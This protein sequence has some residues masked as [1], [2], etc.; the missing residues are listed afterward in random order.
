VFQ[1]V[2]RWEL[3]AVC[4]GVLAVS[5]GVLLLAGRPATYSIE[6]RQRVSVARDLFDGLSRG[7]QA[8][9]GSLEYAP[10]PTILIAMLSVVPSIGP[11]PILARVLAV[12]AACALSCYVY[13]L[14]RRS[15]IRMWVVVPGLLA[16]LL[17]PFSTRSLT[18][19]S[20]VWLLAAVTVPAIGA[21]ASWLQDDRLHD[22]A[23]AAVL[24]GLSVLVAY[25]SLVLVAACVPFVAARALMEHRRGMAEG[26][27]IV[28]LL[29]VVYALALWFGGNWLVMGDP[30]FH[31]KHWLGRASAFRG[32]AWVFLLSDYPWLTLASVGLFALVPPLSAAVAGRKA[33]GRVRQIALLAVVLAIAG[34][35]PYLPRSSASVFD[36]EVAE[37][38]TYLPA[39][40]P[41]E[42]F[43]VVGYEGYEFLKAAKPS[44]RELWVH[45]M[46]LDLPTLDRAL[47]DYRGRRVLLILPASPTAE[48]VS[49]ISLDLR[50]GSP[51]IPDRMLVVEHR[52]RWLVFEYLPPVADGA[53]AAPT[54]G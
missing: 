14:W 52:G 12:L 15:G 50:P 11:T 34:A 18:E 46:K 54:A 19:G 23:L 38:A 45:T 17:M 7:R 53:G 6:A 27:L 32:P 5:A 44:Q 13:G 33:R 9:V 2:A 29:P 42:A 47:R 43:V 30:M 41:Q 35:S 24:F 37:L 48:Y 22:L 10:L 21:L 4:L 51:T 20:S 26:A 8:L 36:P 3:L 16:L 40:Y 39:H 25:Q 49:D 31:V 28:F 1:G